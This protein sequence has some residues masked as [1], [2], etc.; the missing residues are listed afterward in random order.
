MT[1][2]DEKNK[3]SVKLEIQSDDDI[4]QG[5]YSNLAG[6]AHS[7]NEFI[8]DFLFLYPNQPKARLKT[9]IIASPAHAKRFLAA[10]TENI[11]K[12]EEKFGVIEDKAAPPYAHG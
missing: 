6:I 7:E 4:A 2:K 10:L 9:R 12:Y 5:I 11:R 8:I 3:P 1:D